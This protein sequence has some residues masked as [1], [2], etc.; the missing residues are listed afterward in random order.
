MLFIWPKKNLPSDFFSF[1]TQF[2]GQLAMFV[3]TEECVLFDIL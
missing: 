2:S 1:E 3:Q